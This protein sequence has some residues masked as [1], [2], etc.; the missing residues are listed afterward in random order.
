MSSF[1]K[2]YHPYE[3]ENINSVK[4]FLVFAKN[5]LMIVCKK[6]Y[7]EKKDGILIPIRWARN[8]NEWVFDKGTNLLRDKSG[9]T[10]ENIKDFIS[11][12]SSTYTA[13]VYVLN[14]VNQNK[15]FHILGNELNLTKNEN[16]FIAFMTGIGKL[17]DRHLSPI[18]IYSKNRDYKQRHSML[19]DNTTLTMSTIINTLNVP[20]ITSNKKID[21]SYRIAYNEFLEELKSETFEVLDRKSENITI[22]IG[23]QIEENARLTCG[24]SLKESARILGK[25]KGVHLNS[26][27]FGKVLNLKLNIL[28]GEFIKKLLG[29]NEIEGIVVFDRLLGKQIKLIGRNL[30]LN[31]QTY[32]K[33]LTNSNDEYNGVCLIPKVF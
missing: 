33:S 32:S 18:G 31:K 7:Q 22:S 25:E 11:Q 21:Y 23:K 12:D 9:M 24:F 13:A 27:D 28:L 29:D 19:L 17:G 1:I 14:A 16:K 10:L 26:V 6:G 8:K 2:L 5:F 30:I 20:T 15:D 4:K 3:L